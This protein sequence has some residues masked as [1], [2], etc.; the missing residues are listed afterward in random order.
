MKSVREKRVSSLNTRKSPAAVT[1]ILRLSSREQPHATQARHVRLL[2]P[3]CL[4]VVGKS[5]IETGTVWHSFAIRHLP[6]IYAIEEMIGDVNI[7][8]HM[9]IPCL[10]ADTSKQQ[11]LSKKNHRYLMEPPQRPLQK[12][13]HLPKDLSH[14]YAPWR[15]SDF[16]QMPSVFSSD[17]EIREELK[18]RSRNCP[19]EPSWR[20]SASKQA[21]RWCYVF[22]YLQCWHSMLGHCIPVVKSKL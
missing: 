11:Q 22:C 9:L 16:L 19:S 20:T 2:C 4:T 8:L 14:L 3:V 13:E 15:Q 7:Q 21:F 17:K 12:L 18:R 5:P 1:E 10:E 6:R